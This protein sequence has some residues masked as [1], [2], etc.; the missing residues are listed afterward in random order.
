M[1]ETP[2][3]PSTKWSPG[4]IAGVTIGCIVAVIIIVVIVLTSSKKQETIQTR[5]KCAS[6]V[7][8]KNNGVCLPTGIC[9]CANSFY[10]KDCSRQCV[11]ASTTQI[12][13]PTYGCTCPTH[14]TETSSGECEC[15]TKT[16]PLG[17]VLNASTCSCQNIVGTEGDMIYYV[18]NSDHSLWKVKRS[19]FPDNPVKVGTYSNISGG[20]EILA[21]SVFKNAVYVLVK[22]TDSKTVSGFYTINTSTGA[23]V[24]PCV[25]HSTDDVD[26]FVVATGRIMFIQKVTRYVNNIY[27]PSNVTSI[28]TYEDKKMIVKK[29]SVTDDGMYVYMSLISNDSVKIVGVRTASTIVQTVITDLNVKLEKGDHYCID[30]DIYLATGGSGDSFVYKYPDFQSQSIDKKVEFYKET[31]M[32][33]KGITL[34]GI[35]I[36]SCMDS[37]YFRLENTKKLYDNN[38][39]SI[40]DV[41]DFTY[42]RNQAPFA[43]D[44]EK[45]YS[46]ANSLCKCK[47]NVLE[48]ATK[49]DTTCITTNFDGSC[50]KCAP[51]YSGLFCTEKDVDQANYQYGLTSDGI[52]KRLKINDGTI[53]IDNISYLMPDSNTV[54]YM[55]V[56]DNVYFGDANPKR[57]RY[58]PYCV[59]NSFLYAIL[60]NTKSPAIRAIYRAS[61]SGGPFILVH[62][63]A[64]L[65]PVSIVFHETTKSLL[66]TQQHPQDVDT[67]TWLYNPSTSRYYLDTAV[68]KLLFRNDENDTP[69]YQANAFTSL[70]NA[71]TVQNVVNVSNAFLNPRLSWTYNYSRLTS[72]ITVFKE[73]V[74]F[75]SD[76]LRT[77][78]DRK[79]WPKDVDPSNSNNEPP[80]AEAVKYFFDLKN[81]KSKYELFTVESNAVENL[82]VHTSNTNP[83]QTVTT[84]PDRYQ[85]FICAD[86][87]PD[88][89][90]QRVWELAAYSSIPVVHIFEQA[91]RKN[92]LFKMVGK[93]DAELT[94]LMKTVID[95]SH[96]ENSIFFLSEDPSSTV[97]YSFDKQV[98]TLPEVTVPYTKHTINDPG[99]RLLHIT[100]T[101][102]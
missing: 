54:V 6:N 25:Y 95:M 92:T 70:S 14:L 94:T 27:I 31:D 12:C 69:E 63:L 39:S 50:E 87:K 17:Q 15:A 77:C 74:F 22:A 102:Q 8:C 61:I 51:G 36:E 42:V 30:R 97:V 71:C 53:M 78:T 4:K 75:T 16:C 55:G 59:S 10:S 65:S 93:T 11:C 85:Q 82:K 41:L 79:Y 9:T 1:D 52:F 76:F 96:T 44:E 101:Y 18:K 99:I 43:C 60:I 35:R 88:T 68:Y 98:T 89:E 56:D 24:S 23:L 72:N 37:L 33:G 90:T 3:P 38:S 67:K 40:E 46:T 83:E 81:Y 2:Q 86:K 26:S 32:S 5:F 62:Y 34:N 84:G 13:D 29:L 21:V 48:S 66:V 45:Y 7:D 100:T 58:R 49:C 80:S 91:G 20:L 19:T 47:K 57:R 73:N 28:L 64:G